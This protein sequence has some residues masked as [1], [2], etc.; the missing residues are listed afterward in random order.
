MKVCCISDIHENW[1]VKIPDCDI[2]LIAGDVFSD[3]SI[4]SQL[5]QV[6]IHFHTF[7][8]DLKNRGISVFMTPGNHDAIW[9][10]Q[11]QLV[12]DLPCSVLIDQ[13]TTFKFDKKIWKIY[14]SPWQTRFYDWAFNLDEP[15]LE[16]KWSFIPDD[17]E[18]LILHSPPFGILDN[19]LGSPS[20]TKRIEELDSLKLCVFGH[21]HSGFG[22]IFENGKHFVN[23]AVCNNYNNLIRE[24]IVL[25]I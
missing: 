3:P 18:I 10:Y 1:N 2:L 11:P 23:A 12:P 5:R 25:D 19:K 14:G 4:R 8:T 9:E 24:P 17:T 21:I 20:L 15:Q 6:N 7:L 16:R 22:H 13:K